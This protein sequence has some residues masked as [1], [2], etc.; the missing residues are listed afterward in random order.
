[1]GTRT[2]LMIFNFAGFQ[3]VWWA[4]VLGAASGHWPAALGALLVWVLLHVM[5]NR[6]SAAVDLRLAGAAMVMGLAGDTTLLHLGLID[7]PAQAATGAVSPPWM[8]GLWAAFA[9]T[10]GHSLGWLS[11]RYLAAVLLGAVGG[12]A[13]YAGGNALGA[14][15]TTSGAVSLASVAFMYAVATPV[16]VALHAALGRRYPPESQALPAEAVNS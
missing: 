3:A 11:G 15:Q 16:L 5:L 8:I 1:M 12:A 7:F 2:A 14:L 9:L 13:A 6:G 4:L 10:I